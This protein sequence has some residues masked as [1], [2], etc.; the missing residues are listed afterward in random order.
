M[1]HYLL[2]ILLLPGLLMAQDFDSQVFIKNNY[3]NMEDS[4]L[5]QLVLDSLQKYEN[6]GRSFSYHEQNS[7]QSDDKKLKVFQFEGEFCGAYCNPYHLSQLRYENSSSDDA[8]Y[9]QDENIL[10]FDVEKIIYMAPKLYLIIGQQWGRIRSVE[11][12]W[13]YR[14]VLLELEKGMKARFEMDVMTSNLVELERPRAELK[15]HPKSQRITYLYDYY[16][17]EDLDFFTVSGEY[18]FNG[19]NF[20]L[21]N[22]KREDLKVDSGSNN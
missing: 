9:F 13:G 21:V 15:Y 17:E 19:K 3:G 10:D 18:K 12:V 11:S 20:E 5:G 4:L 8:I 1:T 7:I 6:E 22:E 2:P 16:E 14:T